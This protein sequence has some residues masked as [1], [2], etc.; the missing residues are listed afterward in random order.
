MYRLSFRH[1]TCYLALSCTKECRVTFYIMNSFLKFSFLLLLL[2]AGITVPAGAQQAKELIRKGWQALVVDGDTTA[3]R[4]FGE[5]FVAAGK[6]KDTGTR[7]VALLNMGICQYSISYSTGLNYCLQAMEE[8]KRL[9]QS[10]PKLALEGRSKCLQ[11]ISTIKGRQGKYREVIAVSTEAMAGFP[12]ANDTSGYLGL[13][14]TSLG[15]AYEH[16]EQKDS[17]YYFYQKSLTEHLATNNFTYLPTAYINAGNVAMAKNDV[18]AANDFYNKA[19][20]IA[21]S[22][23]NRQAMVSALLARGKYWEKLKNEVEAIHT[24]L[25]AKDIAA[26]L[27]DKLFYLNALKSLFGLCKKQNDFTRALAYREEMVAVSD[28][29]TSL[30]KQRVAKSLEIQFDVAE[31]DRQLEMLQQKRSIAVLTN[32]LLWGGIVIV[33]IVAAGIIIFLTR[34]SKRDKLLLSTKEALLKATE[35]QQELLAAQQ[36][37]KEQQL[38][39]QI[40]YKESQ[41]SAMTLQMLQKNEL[42]QELKD[43]LTHTSDATRDLKLDKIINKGLNQDKD[44]SDFN[45]HFESVNQHFYTRLKAA[46]PDISPNDRKIC[47][48][49]KLNLSIKEMAGVLNISPDSVKTARYRL[50][51]K[52]QLNTEDNLNEFILGL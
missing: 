41:L 16:L 4:L 12:K 48:L 14:Y 26:T 50:R 46:Y 10:N 9:E 31:K 25:R 15:N 22:T 5:A 40:E 8:Y 39:Q 20:L 23:K 3:Y 49:I 37:I 34:N 33:I 13:I 21:D 45:A 44:W 24:Y 2:L 51:K 42:M 36:L 38:R 19:Y 47:A 29:L 11:L 35:S 32:W 30:E 6:E 27:S 7:A 18:A 52:L 17:A 28:S 43:Q 1:W